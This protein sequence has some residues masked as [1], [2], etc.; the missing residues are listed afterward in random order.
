MSLLWRVFRPCLFTLDPERAHGLA[1]QALKTGLLSNKPFDDQRLHVSLSG[2][3]F[4]SPLGLAA[5]FD[6]NGKVMSSLLKLGFGHVEIGTLTP[7]PQQGN[8]RPRL[9]RLNEDKALINRM[10]FNNAGHA[11]L[12]QHLRRRDRQGIVGLNIGANKDST[13]RVADYSAAIELFTDHIDYFTVNISSPNT[14][15]LRDLQGRE[16]L[17]NLLINLQNARKNSKKNGRKP[18]PIFLKIAPDLNETQLDDIAECVLDQGCDGLVIS[19]TTLTREGLISRYRGEGGGLSG[20]PLFDQATIVLAKMRV[21]VGKKLP[22]I[23]V[24]GISDGQ[25]ALEKIRAGANVV[26]ILSGLTYHGPAL[27]RQAAREIAAMRE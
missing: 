1:L 21:R 9:F 25:S 6:K 17:S 23:G 7:R 20:H 13:N 10:G 24:G 5:G 12:L 15:G 19:N 11:V 27:V 4:P 22:I 14:L 2:L 3:E 26:Q 8:P 18:S 16:H